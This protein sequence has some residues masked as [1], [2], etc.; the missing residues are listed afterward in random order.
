[1]NQKLM[2]SLVFIGLTGCATVQIP[3]DR[4]ESS[5]ASIR[6]AEEMGAA[7]V[8][9]A[10]LHVQLARDQTAQAKKLALDGDKRA[11]LVL[12]R[13]ESDAELA[14]GLARE[15]SVRGEA[16]RAADDLNALRAR[17]AP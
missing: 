15:V 17:P 9:A 2:L 5:E 10:K 14:L 13:A 12:A 11:L 1:M 4:L 6:G 8:P 16:Q 7:N 3:P